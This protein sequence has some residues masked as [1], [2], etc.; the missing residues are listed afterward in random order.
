MTPLSFKQ[1]PKY[2]IPSLTFRYPFSNPSVVI[3]SVMPSARTFDLMIF[4][5]SSAL[6]GFV[7]G[8]RLTET[9]AGPTLGST[10]CLMSSI[11][12]SSGSLQPCGKFDALQQV[13]VTFPILILLCFEI[14]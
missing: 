9:H 5:C 8:P 1:L 11:G 14:K 3:V 10:S 12:D 4:R 6:V 13:R 7:G 2:A